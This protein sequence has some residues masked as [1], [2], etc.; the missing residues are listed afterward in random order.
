MVCILDPDDYS[1]SSSD[2]Y[3]P[4]VSCPGGKKTDTPPARKVNKVKAPATPIPAPAP[5]T[6]IQQSPAQPDYTG[7]IEHPE[8]EFST[9]K[10]DDMPD[11]EQNF[12]WS[13]LDDLFLDM[14]QKWMENEVSTNLIRTGLSMLDNWIETFDQAKKEK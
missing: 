2:F 14:R 5:T 3:D 4:L 8:Q 10:G 7:S 13:E 1:L 6:T 11:N 9:I 12:T